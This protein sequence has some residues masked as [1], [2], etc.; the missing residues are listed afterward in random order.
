MSDEKICP[1]DEFRYNLNYTCTF[2]HMVVWNLFWGFFRVGVIVFLLYMIKLNK[3]KIK[4]LVTPNPNI[5]WTETY[6]VFS[7]MILRCP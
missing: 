6:S 5:H 7:L 2:N 3:A 4:I 1:T